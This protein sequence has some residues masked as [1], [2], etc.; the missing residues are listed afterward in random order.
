MR[1]RKRRRRR[2]R[3][4][5]HFLDTYHPTSTTNEKFRKTTVLLHDL[6]FNVDLVAKAIN[7]ALQS[8]VEVPPDYEVHVSITAS[9]NVSSYD[10]ESGSPKNYRPEHGSGGTNLLPL[11]FD[12]VTKLPKKTIR[13]WM[14]RSDDYLQ[15]ITATSDAYAEIEN[16][17]EL[18]IIFKLFPISGQGFMMLKNP[19]RFPN[20]FNPVSEAD[21]FFLCLDEAELKFK[22]GVT[23]HQVK[24]AEKI[25]SAVSVKKIATIIEYLSTPVQV[26]LHNE[27]DGR[28]P[29]CQKDC[30]TI[31]HGAKGN[32]TGL[33]IG[34]INMHYFLIK[35]TKDPI[36]ID[37]DFEKF[38]SQN[39]KFLDELDTSAKV[40]TRD[41]VKVGGNM[42]WDE[43]VS[44]YA[45]MK[46]N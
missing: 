41:M 44:F 26:V 4:F 34:H 8:Y 30:S 15:N 24:Q 46:Q 36:F 20:I 9:A 37:S 40:K 27:K 22:D 29:M 45:L 18:K 23:L 10:R 43:I 14:K 19:E 16:I 33:H 7:A 31:P 11:G 28:F 21:C 12:F 3:E 39:D 6:P 17:H 38:A 2:R 42:L 13:D 1:R 35:N 5:P 32:R 25:G